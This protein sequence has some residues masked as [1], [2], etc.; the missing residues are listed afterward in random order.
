MGL[1]GNK[2]DSLCSRSTIDIV[3]KTELGGLPGGPVVRTSCFHCPGHGFNP[4]SENQDHGSCRTTK[5]TTRNNKNWTSAWE[6]SVIRMFAMTYY[7][8][9]KEGALQ[10]RHHL[11]M[12]KQTGQRLKT[13]TE[14][15]LGHLFFRKSITELGRG[16]INHQSTATI[17][18]L[19]NI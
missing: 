2:V 17:I 13:R 1:H 9:F 3:Y 6:T 12:Q 4:M 11:V 10:H 14:R 7:L 8:G 18:H 15:C 5:R 19:C 16:G